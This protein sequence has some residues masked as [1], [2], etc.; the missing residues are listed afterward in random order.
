MQQ[1]LDCMADTV[2]NP[3]ADLTEAVKVAMS[4]ILGVKSGDGE[5]EPP[6][7]GSEAVY[8]YR[9]CPDGP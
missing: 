4:S 9:H 6:A 1:F 8:M 7:A 3:N 2:A 5:L